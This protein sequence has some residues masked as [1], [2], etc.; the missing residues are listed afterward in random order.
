VRR[1]IATAALLMSLGAGACTVGPSYK[2]PP[3]PEPAAFRFALEGTLEAADIE[4]WRGFDDPALTALVEEA[5]RSNPDVRV[6]AA[7]VDEFAARIGVTRSAAFPQVD[8]D[9]A[10]G[11][12][13][14]SE[15]IG[16]GAVGGDRVS[17]FFEANLSVGWELD[18]FGRIRR[19]TDAAIADTLAAEETRRGVI[20]SLVASVATSY[21]ALRSLDE[22]LEIALRKLQTRR[23]TVELFSLQLERG[24]I[25]RLELAQ[26]QSEFQRTVAQIPALEADIA[27]LENALSVLLGRP[28]G[29][30]PRGRAL[31]ELAPPPIPAGLPSDLLRRRPD[32]RGAEQRLVAAVERV[33]AATADFYPRFALTGA[34]GVASDELSDLFSSSATTSTIAAGAVAPLFTAGFL[35]N[36]LDAAEAVERQAIESYRAAVL[37]AL[38]ESEDALVTRSSSI[39]QQR[40]QAEQVEALARYADLA[41]VRYDNGFVSYLAVLDAERDLFDAE[42]ERSRLRASALA[43]VVGVYKAFGGGWIELA[44]ARADRAERE[45]GSP[46]ASP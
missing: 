14:R 17:D 6:A 4:W 40:A 39:A 16:I 9:A 32:L 33:G 43:S 35:E 11:R 12:T 45:S 23:E 31:A 41:Q 18:V 7:R 44:E 2:R 46:P 1:T 42:L 15:E 30:I 8:A 27:R 13:R 10:A 20:L 38:R 29:P 25:S 19:A 24:V 22:Q 36:R 21:I 5:L 28:P 37:T 3:L 26:I 34:L